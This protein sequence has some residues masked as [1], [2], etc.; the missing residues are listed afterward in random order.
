VVA[1]QGE[2]LAASASETAT[3]APYA[4]L[5]AVDGGV[6]LAVVRSFQEPVAAAA[7]QL[8]A[9]LGE[10]QSVQSDWLLPQLAEPLDDFIGEIEETLPDAEMASSTLDALPSIL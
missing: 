8:D 9:S 3:T 6:D 5:R 4:T 7:A 2:A 1:E 10:L